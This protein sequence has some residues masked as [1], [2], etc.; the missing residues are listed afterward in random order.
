MGMFKDMKD[1]IGVVR[2]DELKELKKKADAQPKVSMM[3]GLKMA[4]KSM[5]AAQEMQT[6]MAQ[7]G[8]SMNPM[9]NMAMMAG[10]TQGNAVVQ[11]ITDT[12]TQINGAPVMEL[13]LEV[14]VPGK[15]PY[16]VKHRQLLAPAVLPNYQPG[17]MFGV[18][19]DQNDPTKIIIG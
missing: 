16:P 9:E 5:D 17:K 2:S 15:E 19:V 10:A 7:S 4:N 13:D 8:M 1:A 14:T 18:R 12:G 6:T 11:A 3:D